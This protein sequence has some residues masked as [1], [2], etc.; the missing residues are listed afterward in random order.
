MD[1]LPGP[2]VHSIEAL[3][4]TV[5]ESQR[6]LAQYKGNYQKY[7]QKFVNY[8]DGQVTERVVNQVFHHDAPKN[9]VQ[10]NRK[11]RIL[12]YPGGMKPNGIT[13][14]I[15]NL[16]ENVDYDR[17]DITVYLGFN[18][19]KDV[20]DNLYSLN[21]NV[22]VILRK[23]PLLANTS[24][25]YRNLLV[26]NRGIKSKIEEKFIRMLCIN[27]NLEKCLVTQRLMSLWISVAMRC[28]GLKSC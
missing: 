15:L 25:Y 19:N 9:G 1:S 5:Q 24:E 2:S 7:K 14:S 6:M 4:A 22:R 11:E 13:T 28:F 3:V 20:I 10:N 16:L 8:D 12:I 27:A 21:D 26:R 23:G 18:R 17:Y